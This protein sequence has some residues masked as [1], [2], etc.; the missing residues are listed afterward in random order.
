MVPQWP[1]DNGR[2]S[3]VEG[4]NRNVGGS[5]SLPPWGD[6]EGLRRTLREALEGAPASPDRIARTPAKGFLSESVRVADAHTAVMKRVLGAFFEGDPDASP[7]LRLLLDAL[8]QA[9]SGRLLEPAPPL[10]LVGRGVQA[11]RV[12]FFHART[13]RDAFI[14]ALIGQPV[15]KK[16][17]YLEAM[18]ELLGELVGDLQ[19]AAQAAGLRPRL[20]ADLFAKTGLTDEDLRRVAEDVA[21]EQ[22]DAAIARAIRALGAHPA[23]FAELP[24]GLAIQKL[25]RGAPGWRTLK[26]RQAPELVIVARGPRGEFGCAWWLPGDRGSRRF[27]APFAAHLRYLLD[28]HIA[29][30]NRWRSERSRREVAYLCASRWLPQPPAIS[31]VADAVRTD[32]PHAYAGEKS[33]ATRAR[34]YAHHAALGRGASGRHRFERLRIRRSEGLRRQLKMR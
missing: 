30:W 1:W 5:E 33:S 18:P 19:Q 26:G 7:A 20:L 2:W 13:D 22:S 29:P 15:P 23:A 12:G 32:Y 16:P 6:R 10:I 9:V 27:G 11:L 31:A 14:E 17:R 34:M 24:V 25:A 28:Y 21:S 4:S 3:N 8:D